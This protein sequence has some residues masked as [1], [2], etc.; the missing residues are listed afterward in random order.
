M[1]LYLRYGDGVTVPLTS[2]G[3]LRPERFPIDHDRLVRGGSG[4]WSQVRPLLLFLAF[5]GHLSIL[6]TLTGP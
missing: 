6:I 3:F 5:S 1:V 2:C 4:I